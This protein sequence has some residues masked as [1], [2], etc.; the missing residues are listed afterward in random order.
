[1][2]EADPPHFLV[3]VHDD[4]AVRVFANGNCE[5]AFVFGVEPRGK[6]PVGPSLIFFISSSRAGPRQITV[7][8]PKN[9]R[10][11]Y[12]AR[13][14]QDPRHDGDALR[15]ALNHSSGKSIFH[16]IRRRSR[17]ASDGSKAL[18]HSPR[19]KALAHNLDRN[20]FARNHDSHHVTAH[21]LGQKPRGTD[22]L[23]AE[24]FAANKP[25]SCLHRGLARCIAARRRACRP[26]A[27]PTSR[28]T[29]AKTRHSEE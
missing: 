4:D 15:D 18:A 3:E 24:C 29:L 17:K 16:F 19:R 8:V 11:A 27:V 26:V 21:R 23:V 28:D 20:V 14:R 12:I 5:P 9:E 6:L 10:D 1:L 7:T 22:R 13:L 25:R 2:I